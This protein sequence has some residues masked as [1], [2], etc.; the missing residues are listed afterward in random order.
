MGSK[1]PSSGPGVCPPQQNAKRRRMASPTPGPCAINT[2]KVEMVIRGKLK[3]DSVDTADLTSQMMC[4][5]FDKALK[6][7]TKAGMDA[8]DKILTCPIHVTDD[9]LKLV[10]SLLESNQ[11][12]LTPHENCQI[13]YLRSFNVE[14]KGLK[15][16]MEDWCAKGLHVAEIKLWSEYI[17]D[18]KMMD[19]ERMYI[20]C[21]ETCGEGKRAWDHHMEDVKRRR[22]GNFA[23]FLNCVEL[24]YGSEAES[25]VGAPNTLLEGSSGAIAEL[26][27]QLDLEDDMEEASVRIW[28]QTTIYEFS[29]VRSRFNKNQ[30]HQVHVYH[31]EQVLIALFNK[32]L[33]LNCQAGGAYASHLSHDEDQNQ[34]LQ[35]KTTFFAQLSQLE[36]KT[37]VPGEI[38]KLFEE[39]SEFAERNGHPAGWSSELLEVLV[40]ESTPVSTHTKHLILHW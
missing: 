40:D 38:W 7:Q 25:N 20:R 19:E 22:T 28:V 9:E 12:S 5:L 21:I 27:Q 8:Y 3:D 33:L 23:A 16:V 15:K 29:S 35:L 4:F 11:T 2:S 18:H 36:H 39:M 13:F 37:E 17:Q 14:V 31:R 1:R 26:F 10:F 34:F 24:K 6:D 30:H 32:S